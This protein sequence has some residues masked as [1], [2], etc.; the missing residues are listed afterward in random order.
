MNSG[1]RTRR[2]TL[3]NSGRAL[4]RIGGRPAWRR[5]PVRSHRPRRP[6]CLLGCV[7]INAQVESPLSGANRKTFAHF[8][9]YRF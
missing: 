6:R 2:R 3:G 5:S 4:E 7:L 1:V 9:T 8:E